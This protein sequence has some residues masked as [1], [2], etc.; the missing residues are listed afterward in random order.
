MTPSAKGRRILLAGGAIAAASVA[1]GWA[2]RRYVEQPRRQKVEPVAPGP[3]DIWGLRFA[4]P[5]GGE[6]VFAALRGRPLVIN[7]WATW[8]APCVEELPLLD[9]FGREHRDWQVVGLALDTESAVQEFLQRTPVGFAIGLAQGEGVALSR[10]LGNHLA[11]L[12]FSVAVNAR[13][14]I[15]SRKLGALNWDELSSWASQVR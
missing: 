5:G 2:L 1:L 6:L 10:S 11:A 15:F 9:R 4:R 7:F 3:V 14:E 8:C 13:G 12:P